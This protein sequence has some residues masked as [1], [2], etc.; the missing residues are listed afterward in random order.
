[1]PGTPVPLETSHPS[2]QGLTLHSPSAPPCFSSPL[3]TASSTPGLVQTRKQQEE[4]SSR[5]NRTW[6]AEHRRGGERH[7]PLSEP[8]N[9]GVAGGRT[10]G[11]QPW[12]MSSGGCKATPRRA[13]PPPPHQPQ[14][15]HAGTVAAPVFRFTSGRAPLQTLCQSVTRGQRTES[16]HSK[17]YREHRDGDTAAAVSSQSSHPASSVRTRPPES[18]SHPPAAAKEHCPLP[19][20][21]REPTAAHLWVL[22]TAPGAHHST[23]PL[24]PLPQHPRVQPQPKSLGLVAQGPLEAVLP[25]SVLGTSSLGPCGAGKR[26]KCAP[27]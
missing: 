16:R 12:G 14:A 24:S 27:R 17:T 6:G 10:P 8:S 25:Q 3:L 2:S 13:P 20:P 11:C 21:P 9:R 22:K 1:M 26:G 18:D 15:P 4:G 7:P 5:S 23:R 19:S